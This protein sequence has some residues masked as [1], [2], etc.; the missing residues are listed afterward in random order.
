MAGDD[1]RHE[2]KWRVAVHRQVG[3]VIS[4]SERAGTQGGSLPLSRKLTLVIELPQHVHPADHSVLG[5]PAA[6][7]PAPRPGRVQPRLDARLGCLHVRQ[8]EGQ[9][10]QLIAD[11]LLSLAD[12]SSGDSGRCVHKFPLF[13]MP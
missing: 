10:G 12:V 3:Q 5:F 7:E 9:R 13:L 8:A 4:G 2:R 6:D 11:R 1:P